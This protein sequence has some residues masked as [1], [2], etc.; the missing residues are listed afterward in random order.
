MPFGLSDDQY[1][2]LTDRYDSVFE[3]LL[4]YEGVKDADTA[5]S[6][7]AESIYDAGGDAYEVLNQ[8]LDDR[9]EAQQA[10]SD[11]MDVD[12]DI[13]DYDQYDLDDEWFY[14]H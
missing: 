1:D 6:D 5:I 12:W 4:E 8:L 11:G 7:A 14:Y 13:S 3:D 2:E 10:Y 9:E